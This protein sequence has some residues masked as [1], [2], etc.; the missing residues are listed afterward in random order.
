MGGA[1]VVS[2]LKTSTLYVGIRRGLTY[3]LDTREELGSAAALPLAGDELLVLGS[4]QAGLE[5]R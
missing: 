4:F 3:S 1:R 5:R 2:G